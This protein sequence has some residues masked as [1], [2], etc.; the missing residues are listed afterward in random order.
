M[1]EKTKEKILLAARQEFTENGFDQA[2]MDQI[3]KRAGVNKVMLYYHFESKENMLRELIYKIIGESK[4][5]FHEGF[6]FVKSPQ[7]LAPDT[8]TQKI[9]EVLGS[10]KD[11]IHLITVEILKGTIDIKIVL[12]TLKG[13]YQTILSFA[14]KK[15]GKKAYGDEFF[16][17]M[18]FFQ[19]IPLILYFHFSSELAKGLEIKKEKLDKIFMEKFLDSYYR[20]FSL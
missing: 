7:E 6:R 18:F 16:I 15:E 10:N 13:F 5:K 14:Q 17:Q 3:A 19:T 8:I 20:T 9:E 1:G 12:D 4:I 11:L 2:K